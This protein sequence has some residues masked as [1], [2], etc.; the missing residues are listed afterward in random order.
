MSKTVS[1]PPLFERLKKGLEESLQHSQGDLDLKTTALESA[2]TETLGPKSVAA[3][4][5]TAK[6]GVET[7][8]R[9]LNVSPTTVRRWERG[10][11]TPS[12]PAVR[13]LQVLRS[14]PR[15]VV[16]CIN[17]S[18]VEVPVSGRRKSSSGALRP[19]RRSKTKS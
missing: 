10:I 3:I 1:K 9:T 4:R 8:A 5:R 17:G 11:Q 14:N 18:L 2:E 7:F 15:A 12:G 6:M 19:S 16:R 13:L